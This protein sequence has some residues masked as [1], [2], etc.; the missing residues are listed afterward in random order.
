MFEIVFDVIWW[1]V[2]ICESK[3]IWSEYSK[4]WHKS[5]EHLKQIGSPSLNLYSELEWKIWNFVDIIVQ[6]ENAN[7]DWKLFSPKSK[8][9]KPVFMIVVGAIAA[10]LKQQHSTDKLIA[11]VEETILYDVHVLC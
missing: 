10:E 9:L 11:V 8:N 7:I 6:I 4:S 1:C 5:L 2:R 3:E